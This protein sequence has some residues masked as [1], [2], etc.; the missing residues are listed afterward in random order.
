MM[1]KT[2]AAMAAAVVAAMTAAMAVAMAAAAAGGGIGGGGGSSH[3]GEMVAVISTIKHNNIDDRTILG[4][5]DIR[6]NIFEDITYK[7]MHWIMH[8]CMHVCMH[9]CT[10]AGM[11]AQTR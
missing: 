3:N 2:V 9:L 10:C 5:S 1:T 4:G 11:R 8:L 6:M 7:S